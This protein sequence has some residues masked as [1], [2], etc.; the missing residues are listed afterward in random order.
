MKKL[1]YMSITIS[2]ACSTLSPSATHLNQPRTPSR[3]INLSIE[4]AAQLRNEL[5]DFFNEKK[6][7]SAASQD[8]SS[9]PSSTA[10]SSSFFGKHVISQESAESRPHEF[11][12]RARKIYFE[13]CTAQYSSPLPENFQ[14]LTNLINDIGK[15]ERQLPYS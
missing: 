8:T 10:S 3:N 9:Q 7:Y 1:L 5:I 15:L 6:K 11:Q 4:E 2:V 14:T 12:R 13:A